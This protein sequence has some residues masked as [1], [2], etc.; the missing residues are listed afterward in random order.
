MAKKKNHY[1]TIRVSA[2]ADMPAVQ[3]RRELRALVNEGCNYAAD[4]GDV[5]IARIDAITSGP[6][7]GPKLP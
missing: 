4:P 1:M 3:V 5:R 6:S 7:S 2:P